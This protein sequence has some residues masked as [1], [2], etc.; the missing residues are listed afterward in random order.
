VQ[1]VE[2]C[3]KLTFG[4]IHFGHRVSERSGGGR[5][6]VSLVKTATFGSIVHAFQARNEVLAY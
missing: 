4:V 3:K 2:K 5:L 1:Q 6:Y